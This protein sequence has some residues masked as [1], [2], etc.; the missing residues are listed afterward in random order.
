M[1]IEQGKFYLKVV[2]GYIQDA[3]SYDPKLNNYILF[4]IDNLPKDIMNQC[5]KVVKDKL[6]LD[7]TKYS[8]FLKKLKE[9]DSLT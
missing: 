8:E 9:I 7:E 6:V 5:Y 1:I 4:E 3:V 2:D